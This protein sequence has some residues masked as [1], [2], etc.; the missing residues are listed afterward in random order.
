[1]ELSEATRLLINLGLN[2]KICGAGSG[3]V[4]QQSLPYGAIVPKGEVITLNTLIL[5][6]ED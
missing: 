6:Y 2:L 1:M 3:T 5:D 4:T